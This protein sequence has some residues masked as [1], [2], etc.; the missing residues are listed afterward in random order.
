MPAGTAVRGIRVGVDASSAPRALDATGSARAAA[1][2][3]SLVGRTRVPTRAAVGRVRLQILAAA[4]TNGLTGTAAA[5]AASAGLAGAAHIA[6]RAAVGR[7]RLQVLTAARTNA[8]PSTAGARAATAGQTAPAHVAACAAVGVVG[9]G[10]DAHGVAL[11]SRARRAAAAGRARPNS[12]DRARPNA[13]SRSVTGNR[14]VSATGRARPVLRGGERATCRDCHAER[15]PKEHGPE[16]AELMHGILVHTS[17]RG[18][19]TLQQTIHGDTPAQMAQLSE[20]QASSV[21]WG[22]VPSSFLVHC[23]LGQDR[24]RAAWVLPVSACVKCCRFVMCS[25]VRPVSRR[26]APIRQRSRARPPLL[27]SCE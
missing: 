24:R 9:I 19:A 23:R 20:Y 25:K 4:G 11:Q 3:A 5:C 18:R 7:V 26:R 21:G 15:Q 27:R 13:P 22:A 16:R 10:I 12:A 8:L 6:A 2:L 1:A 14:A 17:V